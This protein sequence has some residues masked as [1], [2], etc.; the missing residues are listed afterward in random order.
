[1]LQG[2]ETSDTLTLNPDSSYI[3]TSTVQAAISPSIGR[4]KWARLTTTNISWLGGPGSDYKVEDGKLSLVFVEPDPNGGGRSY[5]TFRRVGVS[6]VRPPVHLPLQP[7]MRLLVRLPAQSGAVGEPLLACWVAGDL[8]TAAVSR[9]SGMVREMTRLILNADEAPL[10]GL[11]R[12]PG[13]SE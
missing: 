7:P 9:L 6:E 10:R 13:K 1:M 4:H 8:L 5:L 12:P 2:W 11:V 3:W